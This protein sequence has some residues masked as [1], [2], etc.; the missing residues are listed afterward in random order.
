M[1]EL[2]PEK[3]A[4]LRELLAD[5]ASPMP[6]VA[7]LVDPSMDGHH[8]VRIRS[9]GLAGVR[10]YASAFVADV[11]L[12]VAAVNALPALL[13]AAAERDALAAE[14]VAA[15]R[16]VSIASTATFNDVSGLVQ[17]MAAF[18]APSTL[19]AERDELAAAVERVRALHYAADND[20]ARTPICPDCHGK[21]GI[22]PCGCWA[23]TDR[24]HVCGVCNEGCKDMATP[25]PCATIRALDGG[26]ES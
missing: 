11:E 4:E 24:E 13:D 20:P 12:I 21:A 25:Y 3:L 19:R 15:K 1:S 8:A 5:A 9:A 26:A 22:H 16:L 6:F 14:L 17:D 7:E 10:I 2:T 18:E 23:E